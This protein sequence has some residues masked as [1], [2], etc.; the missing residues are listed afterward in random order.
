MCLFTPIKAALKMWIFSVQRFMV[1]LFSHTYI[2]ILSQPPKYQMCL[3]HLTTLLQQ[4]QVCCLQLT[5]CSSVSSTQEAY[6]PSTQKKHPDNLLT[7]RGRVHHRTPRWGQP[8]CVGGGGIPCFY[9]VLSL[10]RQRVK[11]VSVGEQL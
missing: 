11:C 5:V 2:P 3:F 8:V 4:R 1:I 7:Q 9:M 10:N 6:S